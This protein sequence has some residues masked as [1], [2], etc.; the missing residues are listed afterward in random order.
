MSNKVWVVI[1]I[2]LLQAVSGCVGV[3]TISEGRKYNYSTPRVYQS[4]GEIT[5]RQISSLNKGSPVYTPIK[6][7]KL[8][9][10][11]GEPDSIE[12]ID[13]KNGEILERWTYNRSVGWSGVVV[14]LVIPIPLLIPV[15]Y[16]STIMTIQDG[17][18]IRGEYFSGMSNSTFL[19]GGGP[20]IPF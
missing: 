15:G 10:I 13:V 5:S 18:V 9:E 6:A 1:F 4:I 11:W 19:Y 3:S 12:F 17:N 20:N 16:R 14:W 7:K 2:C 8:V